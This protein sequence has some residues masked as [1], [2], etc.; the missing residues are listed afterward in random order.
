MKT[1]ILSYYAL[2][3]L[4]LSSIFVVRGQNLSDSLRVTPETIIDSLANGFTYIIQPIAENPDKNEIRLIVKAGSNQERDDQYEHAH[5][6]EHIAF[7][8]LEGYT[9]FK[10]DT[11]HLSALQMSPNDMH[12]FTTRASTYYQFFY[13]ITS[14]KALDTILN[15]GYEIASAK[16]VFAKEQIEAEK[17]AVYQ[18]YLLKE[19]EKNYSTHKIYNNLFNCNKPVASPNEFKDTLMNSSDEALQEFYEKWYRPD[20]MTLIVV[21]KF[22]DLDKLETKIKKVFENISL[23]GNKPAQRDCIK[24]YLANP[25]KFLVEPSL[26]SNLS[27]ANFQ[28]YFRDHYKK[29]IDGEKL[30]KEEFW[31]VLSPIIQERLL[32]LQHKYNIDYYSNFIPY[33]DLNQNSLYIHTPPPTIKKNLKEV[34][35]V[36][37]GI[38][39]KGITDTEFRKSIQSRKRFLNEPHTSPVSFWSDY[40]MNLVITNSLKKQNL[41]KLELFLDQLKINDLNE[42]LSK[43]SWIPKDISVVIPKTENGEDY[44][45]E[46]IIGFIKEGIKNPLSDL[47]KKTPT[48]LVSEKE[49]KKLVPARIIDRKNGDNGEEIIKLDNGVTLLLKQNKPGTGRFK[50]KILI[51]GFSSEGSACFAKNDYEAILSPL[52]L[53]N[54]GL[55]DFDKFEINK[56]LKTTSFKHHYRNYITPYE[57]GFEG[58]FEPKDLENFLQMVYLSFSSPEPKPEA[59]LDWKMQE[60]KNRVR[61]SRPSNN[62]MDFID[63][64]TG[65]I[66]IPRGSKR[67]KESLTID[68]KRA[69]KKYDL[70]HSHPEKYTILVVGNYDKKN[71]LPLLRKYIGN[72]PHAPGGEFKNCDQTLSH[73]PYTSNSDYTFIEPVKNTY[74]S[75]KFRIPD[76]LMDFKNEVNLELLKTALNFKLKKLRFNNYLGVYSARAI[77]SIQ[78]EIGMSTIEIYLQCSNDDYDKV[79]KSCNAF[80]EELKSESLG[81]ATMKAIKKSAHLK[82]WKEPTK[83]ENSELIEKL[84]DHH[85]HHIPI[86]SEN[87]FQSY[88]D[89][90]SSLDVKKVAKKYLNDEFRWTIKGSSKSK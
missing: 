38:S 2:A 21:G 6:L 62:F 31:H 45:K 9:N 75:I 43:L 55:D 76:E 12:A 14:S 58:A 17:K 56:F 80:L 22:D 42:Y 81:Q 63:E 5:L 83:N 79:L 52:I 11:N 1:S 90:F 23:P 78:P 59:F 49:Q 74:L 48:T 25:E 57:T 72:L 20:L 86:P 85:Q 89:G 51:H 41:A 50:D 3:V 19:P 54:S 67:Y 30:E 10:Y 39:E 24:N 16:V 47:E 71:T 73:I 40:Y 7:N 64:Q 15:F 65:Y 77:K 82:K 46:D 4:L 60:S 84:Y 32:K 37:A 27:L 68:Y 36:L 29:I 34:F 69:L 13:P 70:L 66:G 53:K 8:Y 26:D 44:V 61:R 87:M 35:A 28:F 18:E 33:Y 88:L